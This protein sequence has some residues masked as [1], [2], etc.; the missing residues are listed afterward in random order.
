MRHSLTRWNNPF[1]SVVAELC[2]MITMSTT[3][4]L[5]LSGSV[6]G[7]PI[8]KKTP[9]T[10]DRLAS[11]IPQ[12]ASSFQRNESG[13]V[14]ERQPRRSHVCHRMC[15]AT[16][17]T[18]RLAAASARSTSFEFMSAKWKEIDIKHKHRCRIE[19]EIHPGTHTAT[20]RHM[21]D[22]VCNIHTEKLLDLSCYTDTPIC[23]RSLLALSFFSCRHLISLPVDLSHSH[24]PG[25]KPL[26]PLALPLR[27][28]ITSSTPPSLPASSMYYH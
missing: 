11:N 9:F 10:A 7:R 3:W 17:F 16:Q 26:S 14:A 28:A 2:Y 18:H 19:V 23:D 21:C 22:L 5:S 20:T 8:S 24:C 15:S 27:K 1:H 6:P 4:I 13:A 25:W 12:S